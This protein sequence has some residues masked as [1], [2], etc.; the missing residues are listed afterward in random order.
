MGQRH[1]SGTDEMAIIEDKLIQVYTLI[2]AAYKE[3]PDL[4]LLISVYYLLLIHD[5]WDMICTD[6]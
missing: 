2:E 4:H 5:F 3:D 6:F 1:G